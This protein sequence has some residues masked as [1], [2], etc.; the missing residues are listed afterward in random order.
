VTIG[1]RIVEP[2]IALSI[3]YV[4][5]E[6]L[7]VKDG[8]KRWRITFPF[9]LIHG[10]GF[11]SALQELELPR[12]QL[13]AA[14]FA[15]NCGVEIGQLGVLAVILPLVLLARKNAWVRDRG[16]KIASLGIALAGVTWFVARVSR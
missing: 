7:F 15:F 2:A 14:L 13:P 3:A 12:A 6:N 8:S 1:P 5:I 11:A 16:V 10:F 4:G 9:G